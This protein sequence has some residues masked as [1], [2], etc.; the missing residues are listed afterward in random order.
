MVISYSV[1][2][3]KVR[4]VIRILGRFFMKMR[5]LVMKFREIFKSVCVHVPSKLLRDVVRSN[6]DRMGQEWKRMK[7][8]KGIGARLRISHQG[9]KCVRY[10]QDPGSISQY[11]AVRLDL[12]RLRYIFQRTR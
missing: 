12:H 2:R 1:G 7:K 10:H 11:W 4:R 5:A 8:T 6:M 3:E 9:V